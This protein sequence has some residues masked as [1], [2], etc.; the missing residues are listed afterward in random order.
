MKLCLGQHPGKHIEARANFSSV[1]LSVFSAKSVGGDLLAHPQSLR[2][3]HD[4]AVAVA[5]GQ[6]A[7]GVADPV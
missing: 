4:L 5:L 7:V 2:Q 3:Q 1:A 6:L